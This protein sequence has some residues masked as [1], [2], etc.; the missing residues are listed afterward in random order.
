MNPA[1]SRQFGRTP[2]QVTRMG[3]GYLMASV[4]FLDE[5]QYDRYRLEGESGA[6]VRMALVRPRPVR[7][8]R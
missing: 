2:I 4:R 8:G 6:S 1:E 5:S 7:A 3:F